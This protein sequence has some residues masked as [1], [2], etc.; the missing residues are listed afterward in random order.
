M[1]FSNMQNTP[2]KNQPLVSSAYIMG[3]VALISAFTCINFVSPIFGGLGI[4]FALLSKGSDNVLEKK[5]KNGLIL[6]AISL[7]ATVV[8]TVVSFIASFASLSQYSPDELHDYLN[9]AY[10]E[11]YGQSFDEL[12]EEIYGED[13]GEIYEETFKDIYGDMQ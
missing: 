2:K 3:I 11:T 1:D 5:A 12:Y 4:L 13:F 8:F 6:S 7:V 10:E 9:E